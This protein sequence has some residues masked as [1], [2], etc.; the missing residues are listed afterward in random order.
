MPNDDRVKLATLRTT[1]GT[2]AVRVDG[3]DGVGGHAIPG[4]ADVG[5][6]LATPDW[7]RAPPPQPDRRHRWTNPTWRP[8]V[9]RPARSSASG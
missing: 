5:A 1:D 8:L 7:A 3:L 9:P 4:V 6:L 2:A